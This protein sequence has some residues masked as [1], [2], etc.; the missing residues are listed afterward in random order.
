MYCS[1]SK[2]VSRIG[3]INKRGW[4]LTL[5]G[6]VAKREVTDTDYYG[7][8]DDEESAK[9]DELTEDRLYQSLEYT[10]EDLYDED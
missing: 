7:D 5:A 4:L 3:V 8:E 9:Y 2:F 1:D 10:K 6:D